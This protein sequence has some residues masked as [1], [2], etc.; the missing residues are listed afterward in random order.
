[1]IATLLQLALMFTKLSLLS[2]G[3]SV[4]VMGQMEQEVV[5]HGWMTPDQFLAA[6]ALSQATPGP[7]TLVA[8]PIGYAAAGLPGVA[9]ALLTFFGPTATLAAL[10]TRLW[11]K[12]R[13]A[14]WAHKV[15]V[16]VTPVVI[17]L[18]AAGASTLASA[19][20]HSLAAALIALGATALMIKTKAPV[21]LIVLAA[22]LAGAAVLG[23]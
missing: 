12:Q 11:L 2:I 7:G 19:S 22:G 20:I 10:A 21:L 17:G 18:I 5:A 16:G 1:M 15:R 8:I 13:G 23:G 4:T 3:S 9:V 6:Y 14:G